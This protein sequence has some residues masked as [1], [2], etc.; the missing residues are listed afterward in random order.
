[1]VI[2][3]AERFLLFLEGILIK[4]VDKINAISE[5]NFRN[6]SVAMKEVWKELKQ[7]RPLIM[8]LLRY[9]LAGMESG[10][11]VPTIIEILG[12]ERTIRRIEKCREW[13]D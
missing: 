11:G 5:W 2:T 9:A 12:K 4:A 3:R 7:P 13:P 1:L 10:V 6:I 8:Q